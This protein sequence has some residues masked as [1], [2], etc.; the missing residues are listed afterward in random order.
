MRKANEH[1]IHELK[2]HPEYFQEVNKDR[3]TAEIR[4]DDRGFQIGDFLVLKEWKSKKK[5]YTG[6][7]IPVLV[8]GMT[9]LCHVIPEVGH[10]WVVMYF[11][12]VDEVQ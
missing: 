4:F 7:K 5:E 3:K 12:R 1:I 8:V 11:R 10:E 9:R 6:R 2:I